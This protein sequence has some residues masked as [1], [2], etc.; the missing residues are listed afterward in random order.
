MSSQPVYI[1]EVG[2]GHGKFSFLMLRK[3]L[4]LREFWPAGASICYV[5]TDFTQRNV[6]FWA[7]H[8]SLKE[9]TDQGLLDFAVFGTRARPRAPACCAL[10]PPSSRADAEND[11]SMTLQVSGKL[12]EKGAVENPMVF[13][14][15]YIFDTLRQVRSP[16]LG[17]TRARSLTVAP[18]RA[19]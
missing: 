6:E 15:N 1:V 10:T 16:L 5:M 8:P 19:S 7:E 13:I 9:F 3:L 17:A 2:A 14:C 11:R 4:A 12:L 18:R